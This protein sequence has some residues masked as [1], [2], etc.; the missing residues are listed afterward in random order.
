MQQRYLPLPPEKISLAKLPSTNPELYGREKELKLLDDAWS[1][2]KTNIVCF[3]AWGG[4][5]KTA[6]VNSWL[7]RNE[8]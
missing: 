5:G 4:V 7:G 3:V 2:P 6:L 1:N 8:G